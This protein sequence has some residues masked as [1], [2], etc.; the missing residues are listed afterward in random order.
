MACQGIVLGVCRVAGRTAI[1]RMR[2]WVVATQHWT[3]GDACLWGVGRVYFHVLVCVFVCVHVHVCVCVCVCVR[4]CVRACGWVGG[5]GAALRQ[6]K[7]D[8]AQMAAQKSLSTAKSAVDNILQIQVSLSR[9]RARSLS[10]RACIYVV[11]V[12]N[13]GLASNSRRLSRVYVARM[14]AWVYVARLPVVDEARTRASDG[15]K[16]ASPIHELV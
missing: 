2:V 13:V 3:L 8:M 11:H 5:S 7:R 9:A 4:A 6:R 16:S 14:R 15:D 10:V 1:V 12:S